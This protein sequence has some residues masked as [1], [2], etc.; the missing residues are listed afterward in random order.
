MLL[1]DILLFVGEVPSYF[2]VAGDV[3]CYSV[4]FFGAD[5]PSYFV[6]AGDV[7]CY[8]VIAGY[9]SFSISFC[10]CR[11]YFLLLCDLW[12]LVMFHLTL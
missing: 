9:R 3:S 8:S 5:V 2:V 1:C 6:V 10:S 12:L 11:R 4:I 7:S